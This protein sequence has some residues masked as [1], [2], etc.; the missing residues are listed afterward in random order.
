MFVSARVMAR[1]RRAELLL[2]QVEASKRFRRIARFRRRRL[3]SVTSA[4]FAALERRVVRWDGRKVQVR[5]RKLS[6]VAR[7]RIAVLVFY[8]IS[9]LGSMRIERVVKRLASVVW[10]PWMVSWRSWVVVSWRFEGIVQRAPVF[11]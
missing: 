9:T 8:R 5:A 7:S 4:I 2:V 1:S 10:R 3:V 11:S 6:L